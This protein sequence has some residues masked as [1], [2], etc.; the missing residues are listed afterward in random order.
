M[1]HL[2]E[3]SD[4]LNADLVFINHDAM[5]NKELFE[6]VYLKAKDLGFVRQDFL[7][8]IS[9]REETFPTG[10]QL[11]GYGVAIPHTDAECVLKEFIAVLVNKE[12]VVFKNMEDPN[13][14]V[15][16]NLVFMLGLNQAHAQLEMLQKLMVFIQDKDKVQALLAETQDSEIINIIKE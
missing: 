15:A 3:I 14:E 8:R 13:Q 11:E 6:K 1:S 7:E 12:P 4:Y 2:S 9:Q 16:T 5:T 10:L